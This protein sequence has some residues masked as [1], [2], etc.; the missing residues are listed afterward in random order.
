[1]Q[2]RP[3]RLQPTLLPRQMKVTPPPAMPSKPKISWL[4]LLLPPVA[5]FAITAVMAM[6]SG[7]NIGSAAF[8]LLAISSALVS[9]INYRGQVKDFQTSSDSARNTFQARITEK[10]NQ[11]ASW[12]KEQGDAFLELDPGLEECLKWAQSESF[13][14]GERRPVDDDFLSIRVGLGDRAARIVIEA[15]PEENIDSNFQDLLQQVKI[16]EKKYTK[17]GQAPI[18]VS[19]RP[20][21]HLAITGNF[22][23]VQT[24]SRAI[25][26]Q[27]SAQHWPSEVEI[28]AFQT[29]R[30]AGGWRWL[31]HLPHQPSSL[32]NACNEISTDGDASHPALLALDNEL[33]RRKSLL[34]SQPSHS[35]TSGITTSFPALVLV[36]ETFSAWTDY[37]PLATLLSEGPS[38]GVYGIFLCDR[39]EDCPSNCSAVIE[40]FGGSANLSFTGIN[41]SNPQTFI[42]EKVD[43]DKAEAFA[44]H[45]G[46]IQWQLPAFSTEPPAHLTL[47]DMFPSQPLDDLPIE[48]WWDEGSPFPYLCA[49]LGRFS[50][51]SDLVFN[52]NEDGH[53]PHGLIGGATGSGKS[54]VLKTLILALALTH[55]PFDLNF[56]LIDYKGGGAFNE[57][58]TLPHVAG[59]ITDIENHADYAARV[60]QSLSGEIN[61]RKQLFEE[62]RMRFGLKRPHI[63]DYRALPVRRP[64]PRLVIIFDE[65]AEFKD[66]HPNE[67]QKLISIARV[68]RSLGVHLI[69]CTQN[70]ARAVDDQVRQNIKF[71]IC[72]RVASAEDSKEMIGIPDAWLISAGIGFFHVTQPQKFKIAFTGDNYLAQSGASSEDAIV[73]IGPDKRR[74]VLYPKDSSFTKGEEMN[75]AQAIVRRIGRAAANLNL[76]KQPYV[77]P[78]PLEPEIFLPQLFEENR[79]PMAWQGSG[80]ATDP[81]DAQPL[82]LGLVDHPAWQIQPLY[83]FPESGDSGRL[84]IF[85]ASGSGKSIFLRTLATSL[86][87]TRTPAQ[88]YIY[89]LDLG[90]GAQSALKP[91]ADLPHLPKEGGIIT[92]QDN[93][94]ISRLF[95]VFRN[96]IRERNVL[97]AG[98][99][100]A[101]Y[102]ASSP[103]DKRQPEIFLLID[104][105]TKAFLSDHEGFIQQLIEIIRGGR[106]AGIYIIITAN[107]MQDIQVSTLLSDIP[108]RISLRQGMPELVKESVGGL[109][110][111]LKAKLEAGDCPPGRG[112]IKRQSVLEMQIA[113]PSDGQNEALRDNVLSN[114]AQQM[115]KTWI[116]SRPPDIHTLPSRIQLHWSSLMKGEDVPHKDI[117]W[118]ASGLFVPFGISQETL[119]PVGFAIDRESPSYLILSTDP[120]LGKT[121]T[122]L[123]WARGLASYYTCKQVQLQIIDFHR[124]SLQSLSDSPLITRFVGVKSELKSLLDDLEDEVKKRR[125]AQ[126]KLYLG[127]PAT[128]RSQRIIQELGCLVILIDDYDA[129]RL[130]MDSK[131]LNTL[132]QILQDGEDVGIRL[133]A[134]E[135]APLIGNSAS[136]DPLLKRPSRYGCGIVLG[137]TDPLDILNRTPKPYNQRTSN[138][139]PGRGYIVRRGQAQLFQ[140]LFTSGP[141]DVT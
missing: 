10:E 16:W 17:I 100:F 85:G 42:P 72:L 108:E 101:S 65:Y 35:K 88:A 30:G 82:V 36:I 39:F 138:L 31:D 92:G 74:E 115:Q 33:R 122:L 135:S 57:L 96:F 63:D 114:L 129:L 23:D 47:L 37:S 98:K 27:L 139:P 18:L 28:G 132:G 55:H 6:T 11:L 90:A 2:N 73:R 133:I 68:G 9:Y 21:G 48:K 40:H 112:F 134:A 105:L 86:A 3:P 14:L 7:F 130:R 118:P 25:V 19:L 123:T 131:D 43:L 15:S 76:N 77:W 140:M 5:M 66:R 80:W 107:L 29:A 120:G 106:S 104:G 52:L 91:L 125:S 13:R 119:R 121:K 141:E 1:M 22:A 95:A 136:T 102:N 69:L 127:S 109:P 103:K 49:P 26:I 20:N 78:D 38:L 87:L 124:H 44:R 34:D 137:G 93:E 81:P 128:F 32:V 71:K 117:V 126:E 111:A 79:I 62:A 84:L 113:L 116:G 59:V 45:M 4:G 97:F 12:A 46:A 61:R 8:L 94:R 60:I 67:C 75:Q 54:E 99:D 83:R 53:G 24:L 110:D 58:R 89:C 51:T 70:P 41:R 50:A 64:I 56:A